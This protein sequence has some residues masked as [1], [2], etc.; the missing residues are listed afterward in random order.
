MKRRGTLIATVVVAGG[1]V[2]LWIGSMK[3]SDASSP[4]VAPVAL[5][6]APVV[7][8]PAATLVPRL[9]IGAPDYQALAENDAHPGE[10]AVR[11]F[12]EDFMAA[13]ADEVKAHL[14]REKI[15]LAET[16]ELTYFA[17][18]ARTSLDWDAVEAVTGHPIHPNARKYATS[19]M[20]DAS[21]QMKSD[22]HAEVAA[23]DPIDK[24]W[25]TIHDIEKRY[26]DHYYDLTGMT[27]EMLD[28]LEYE[29]IHN[30][31]VDSGTDLSPNAAAPAGPAGTH[32]VDRHLG[33]GVRSL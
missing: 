5:P 24:R 30:Q 8:P 22:L 26:L 20:F 27:P 23:N 11:A 12:A 15:S 1:A 10:S 9:V 14:A 16:K 18:V 25:D 13:Q 6:T 32:S 28:W 19:A 29:Q 7:P 4:T 33:Q 17:L 2:A 21:E 3:T 31:H